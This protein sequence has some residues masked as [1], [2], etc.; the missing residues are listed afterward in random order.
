MTW[1]NLASLKKKLKTNDLIIAYDAISAQ[2][3]NCDVGMAEEQYKRFLKFCH[4]ANCSKCP[5]HDAIN[6]KFAW[7]QMSYEEAK[8]EE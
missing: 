2:P 4:G 6:C 5:V 7:A 1:Q 3:R 8:G